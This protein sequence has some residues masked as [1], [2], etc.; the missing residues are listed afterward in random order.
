MR[1]IGGARFRRA[2]IGLLTIMVMSMG[3]IGVQFTIGPA[4]NSDAADLSQFQP[5]NIIADALFWDG[6][7]M[8]LTE[9]Q[10]F[11]NAKVPT[12]VA[13]Y[14]CLKN[15]RETTRDISATPMCSAYTG[16]TNETAAQ[17]ISKVALACGVSPKVILVTLQKEQGLVTSTHPTAGKYR[18]A[19]GAGCPDTA[20][21]DADYYGFFNQV[22]YGAYLLKR[23]TQPPGTGPGTEW[24]T[25]YDLRYP[26]GTTSQ[27]LYYPN[28]ACGT[29]SVFIENQATHALYTYTPYTPNAAALAAGYGIGDACS[30][31]GNRNFFHFYTDWFG[32]TQVPQMS[33]LSGG[34]QILGVQTVGQW[35]NGWSGELKP[36]AQTVKCTWKR[37]GTAVAGAT[38]CLYQLQDADVG[39]RLT[40]TVTSTLV[41][42]QT[43]IQTSAPTEPIAAL[44]PALDGLN[45]LSPSRLVDTRSGPLDTT[46]DRRAQGTGAIP[47]GQSLQVPILGRGG[48][49]AT[50]VGAVA[51]NVTATASISPSHLVVY[52]TGESRP[53]A[54]NLNFTTKQSIANMVIAKIGADGSISIFNSDG[55]T[56]VIVDVAGWF[57]VSGDYQ[58]L[59]PT[60]IADTRSGPLDKTFDGQVEGVGAVTAGASLKVPILGRAGVPATG[61]NAV[62]LN[63]TSTASTSS[64]FLTVYPTGEARPV[65]SNVNFLA[66]TSVPNMVIA[67]IGADGSISIYNSDGATHVIV[68]IAGWFPE[69]SGF[70]SLSPA[71]IAD[72]RSGTGNTTVDGQV[73]GVGAVSAGQ[74]LRV[75]VL[76][77]GG[78]P[79]A[80]VG[81]VAV[82]VTATA[83]TNASHLVVFPTGES[84]PLSS[85][86]NFVARQSVANMV[87]A[88]IG[89]DGSIS[90]Y[91]SDGST[92]LIVDIAGW[93]PDS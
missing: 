5:G 81:A 54:S 57:P 32:S 33:N 25:R 22:H 53:L 6:D 52:P 47:G 56:H 89:A 17:I 35:V 40:V 49:P 10:N 79:A 83:S 19:M 76:G 37:A 23:Y 87:I 26:V 14:T 93:F 20:A 28:S 55:A 88:K 18:A 75:P 66:G 63:V 12:C 1:Y 39:A 44:E 38:D 15:Y 7:A 2:K 29:K 73:Q 50:G 61:V 86:L 13:G 68:D 27:I 34:P 78:V 11:L 80:G 46:L 48:V 62:A 58:P 16:A 4:L 24:W 31:Y 59:S 72:T 64:S 70:Q 41:G 9:I 92:H 43:L 74:S 90:I 85:N 30:T 65:A 3:L 77:R 84:R 45:P 91:N 8:T 82:N 69:G 71:R 51:L 21:C 36:A 42:Y 60:R 67:K